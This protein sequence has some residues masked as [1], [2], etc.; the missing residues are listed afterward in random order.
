MKACAASTH[1][2]GN[3]GRNDQP[4]AA[5][6]ARLEPVF[7][8]PPLGR[9][10]SR[11]TVSRKIQSR[12]SRSAKPGSPA[13]NVASPPAHSPAQKLGE[14]WP[15]IVRRMDWDAAQFAGPAFPLLVKFIFPPK[16]SRCRCIPTT[17]MLGHKKRRGRPRQNRNV[18]RGRRA[19]QAPKFWLGLKPEVTRESFRAPSTTPRSKTCSSS[20]SRCI[21]RRRYFRSRRNRAHHRRRARPL[22]NPADI[23]TSRT[24]STITIAATPTGKP[25]ELHIEKAFDVTR[26]GPQLGG[27][28]ESGQQS[29]ATALQKTFLAACRYFATERWQFS[30]P[31]SATISPENFELWFV[32]H[33]E[34]IV[35]RS[36]AIRCLSL[37][38]RSLAR[39]RRAWAHFEIAP[40]SPK[41]HFAHLR[42]AISLLSPRTRPTKASARPQFR[43]WCFHDQK[44]KRR[45]AR[46]CAVHPRRR[47]RHPLLAPQPHAHAQATAEHRRRRN[48]A[49]Q[50]VERLSPLF[51]L[52]ISGWSPTPSK[53]PPF[54]A[55]CRASLRLTSSPNL[56]AATPPPPS[57]SPPFILRHEHG[58]AIMAVLSADTYIA[59]AKSYRRNRPRR[60]ASI[61]AAPGRLVCPRHSAHA[62]RNRLRL[63]RTRQTARNAGEYR[64]R[65]HRF[66]EK[67]A[68]EV[69]RQYVASG[70]YFWNAGMFFWRVSTFLEL[71][72]PSLPKTHA[73][74]APS[75]K[76][77]ALAIPRR[78][79]GIY[80]QLENISV[81]YA[82][83][84]PATQITDPAPS[85]S[86]PPPSAGATS[87]PG[88]A[89]YQLLAKVPAPTYRRPHFHADASGNFF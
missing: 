17:T 11:S 1:F 87:A 77:S 67:P 32:I 80:P 44:R 18:V 69:A 58:D 15:E 4:G 41:P 39:S 38:A 47:P 56:S 9:A 48:H 13:T 81:D 45:T 12:P 5:L 64:S 2:F 40:E 84:E 85:P 10:H 34:R 27:K 7:S 86:S 79:K 75:R 50:T 20:T 30:K 21:T 16:S 8:A 36:N 35:S 37:H 24:A 42:A 25:R 59:D 3:A 76:P 14:A 63:H 74:L 57:A 51:P 65:V 46:S 66:T 6:P 29:T 26:F 72:A 52:A 78:A 22:R 62:P 73:A 23:P 89:V 70:Q 53:P 83:V 55:N 54:A 82:I 61:A 19:S 88:H 71:L 68:L 33:G 43:A 60:P 49:P 31:V 28:L